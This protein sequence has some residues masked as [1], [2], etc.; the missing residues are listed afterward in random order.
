MPR[1]RPWEVGDDW[2]EKVKLLI[3]PAPSRA[4][5]GRPRMD[6]RQVFAAIIYVLR[7]RIQ[8]KR[9]PGNW[10]RV[11][12]CMAVSKSGNRKQWTEQ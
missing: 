8:W 6:N 11:Q 5:G 3:P 12:Q 9:C 2:W 7:T 1:T 10:E 4:K